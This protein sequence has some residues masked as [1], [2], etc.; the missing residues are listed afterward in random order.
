MTYQG[1]VVGQNTLPVAATALGVFTAG[2]SQG[3]IVNADGTLN[4]ASNPA[5][6]GSIVYF[7]ATGAGVFQGPH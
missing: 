1:G 7:Y 3:L 6:A 5:A 2:G 4:S